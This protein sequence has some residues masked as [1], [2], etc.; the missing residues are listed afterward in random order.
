M[1]IYWVAFL[2]AFAGVLLFLNHAK[3]EVAKR[4]QKLALPGAYSL[5]AV[6]GGLEV[7]VGH[8]EK[9]VPATGFSRPLAVRSNWPYLTVNPMGFL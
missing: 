4:Q 1:Y 3:L 9:T 5:P 7:Q 2:E 8:I 6:V